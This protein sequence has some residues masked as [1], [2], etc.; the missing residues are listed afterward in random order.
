MRRRPDLLSGEDGDA[1]L[2]A[3]E[4]WVYSCTF[5]VPASHTAGEEDPILNTASVS[6]DDLDDDAVTPDSSSQVSVDITHTAGTLTITKSADVAS[7]AHGG[8]VTYT[9]N[10][11][12]IPGADGSPAQNILVSDPQCDSAPVR[13]AD[14][15]GDDDALLE[16][17]ETWVYSCTFSVPASHSAG[18]EDPILNTAS[19]SG[20]DLDDDAV[21][22]DS[23]SQVSVDI[24][25][26]PAP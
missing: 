21:T 20:D 22:P 3:G 19:V 5:S 23:S 2:E 8:T 12:Y 24:T 15:A 14:N 9:F 7:V 1:L 26:T 17:G 11:T 10:V 6:G 25:H 13:G 16:A 4:T 18:E